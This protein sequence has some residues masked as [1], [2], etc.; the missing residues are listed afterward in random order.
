[1]AAQGGAARR[2]LRLALDLSSSRDPPR[3]PGYNGRLLQE[4]KRAS[5]IQEGNFIPLEVRPALG[6]HEGRVA[7][8]RYIDILTE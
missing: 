4:Q 8:E 7:E 6:L 5:A 1:M 2:G 3:G